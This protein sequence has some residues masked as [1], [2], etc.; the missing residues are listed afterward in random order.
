MCETQFSPTFL[1]SPGTTELWGMASTKVLQKR[2][3]GTDFFSNILIPKKLMNRNDSLLHVI[4]IRC[5]KVSGDKDAS[6]SHRRIWVR[7]IYK[8]H[9]QIF[10][11][12][13]SNWN[14]FQFPLLS[15]EREAGVSLYSTHLFSLRD[16]VP[17]RY[18]PLGHKNKFRPSFL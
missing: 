10:S 18:L 3:N 6:H 11:I 8:L 13:N 16:T 2:L 5:L 14:Y 15:R 17:P 1:F 7:K 9:I 12:S 4:S